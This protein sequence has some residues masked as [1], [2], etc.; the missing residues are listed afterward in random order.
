M[1]EKKSVITRLESGEDFPSKK[2]PPFRSLMFKKPCL[3]HIGS[4]FPDKVQGGNKS[5]HQ[6]R[7]RAAMIQRTLGLIWIN[8][9]EVAG[10]GEIDSSQ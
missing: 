2:K 5:C 7:T 3:I 9:C 10:S 4:G 6:R 1:P 8:G